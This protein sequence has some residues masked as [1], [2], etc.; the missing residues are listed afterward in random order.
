[1]KQADKPHRTMK[2]PDPLPPAQPLTLQLETFVPY[3]L[4]VLS[5]RVSQAISAEY[6]RR[7]GLVMT[8]WRTMCVLGRYPG[9]SAGEVAEQTAMDK[10]A[11]SRAVA[12]L[13]ERGLVSRDIHGDDRRRSVLALSEKGRD[14]HDTVAPLVLE[15]ERRLLSVLDESEVAQLHA[16]MQRLAGSGMDNLLAGLKDAPVS[17]VSSADRNPPLG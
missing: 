4:S 8:E 2:Q 1:M 13:L 16:L 9:L 17:P 11:V 15:C 3:Q 10:V 14:L 5:N 12:R 6:Y 7:F